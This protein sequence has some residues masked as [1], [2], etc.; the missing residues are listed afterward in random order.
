MWREE[1][2]VTLERPGVVVVEEVI[3]VG[4]EKEEERKKG[5][6]KKRLGRYK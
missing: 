4:R 2:Q 1:G 6:R 3:K 5:W